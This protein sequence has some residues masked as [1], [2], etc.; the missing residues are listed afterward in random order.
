MNYNIVERKCKTAGGIFKNYK[1]TNDGGQYCKNC[2]LGFYINQDDNLCYSNKEKND[3]Y[4]CI[5]ENG[6]FCTQCEEN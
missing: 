6:N 2:K 4:K 5:I 3:F 1:M